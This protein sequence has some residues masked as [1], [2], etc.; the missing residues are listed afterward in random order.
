MSEKYYYVYIT[1]NKYNKV[2]YIG[3]TND[4]L[5]RIWEYKTKEQRI[6]QFV[7]KY[8]ADKLVWYEYSES[9]NDSLIREKQIKGWIRQKKVDLINNFNPGWKDLSENFSG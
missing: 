6:S 9:I 3:V 4:L 8:N 1:T 5:R 2:L 7:R